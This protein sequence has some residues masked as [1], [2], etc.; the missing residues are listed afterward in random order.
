MG[1]FM[2][3]NYQNINV[4][5]T[6]DSIIARKV[7]VYDDANTKKLYDL[8][9]QADVSFTNLEVL[10]NDFQGY[11]A[12]R[13]DGAHFAAHSYVLDDLQ[14]LGFNLFSCANNHSLDYG[15]E[16]LLATMKELDKRNI[17]YA[18]VGKNLTEARMP[19]YYETAGGTVSMLSATSTFFIEDQA[20]EAR[21]EVPGRPGSNPL[22]FDVEYHVTKEQM[23]HL[24]ELDRALGFEK[25]REEFIHLGFHSAVE[26][27]TILPF[28]DTN[29]RV[30]GTLSATFRLADETK[31]E[32]KPNERDLKEIKK[33]IKEARNRSDV[34][35]MSLHA[36][37]QS[38]SR[39][40]PAE[41]IQ[42][43]AKQ[44]IDAG[45]DVVVMHGPHLLRG[46]EIYEGK[47]I[48]YS[49]GNFIGHNEL[50]YKLPEDS[51]NRFGVA[52]DKTPGVIFHKRSDGGKKGFPSSELYWQSVVPIC[53]F[54]KGQLQSMTLYPIALTNGDKP[55]HRG[56][57]FLATG[58][59]G[60]K[61]MQKFLNLSREYGTNFTYNDDGVATIKFPLP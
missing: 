58:E 60:G 57:P 14:E 24:R 61:I 28:E 39:E 38:I 43:F 42:T 50:V 51:Y 52:S 56:R 46:L 45:A 49:L 5:L 7:S 8:I 21:A 3:K 10:P 13:S 53:N 47:P 32:T 19:V 40:H 34:V 6:G 2:M 26:D 23:E 12:A 16:G 4:A 30:A 25:H 1:D 36:H 37:E 33:W 20:G 35:I 9:K 27:E 17:A 22:A 31:V 18:G 55:H 11:P 54:A 59:S 44:V 15:V 29:L 48:F 41:F